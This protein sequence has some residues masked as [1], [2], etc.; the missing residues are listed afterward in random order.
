MVL[1]AIRFARDLAGSLHDSH[2]TVSGDVFLHEEGL[3]IV[4]TPH[5]IRWLD[6][7]SVRVNNTDVWLPFLV[8]WWL[9]RKIRCELICRAHGRVPL[10]LESCEK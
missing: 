10:D 1:K 7:V 9:R 4:L 2:W 8:R 3:T 5:R 6:E